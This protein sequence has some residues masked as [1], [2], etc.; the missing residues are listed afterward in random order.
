MKKLTENQSKALDYK[1]HIS[2]TANAGSGKTFVFAKRYVEIAL[3]N[4]ENLS[5]IVAI[6]FT[7]KAAAELYKKISEELKAKINNSAEISEKNRLYNIRRQ[8]VSA[9]IS[10]IHSFCSK[11]LKEFAPELGL[12]SNFVLID[13]NHSLELLEKSFD[14]YINEYLINQDDYDIKTLLRFFGN[15]K[16]FFAGILGLIQ[17][18]RLVSLLLNKVNSLTDDDL[19]QNIEKKNEEFFDILFNVDID[20]ILNDLSLLNNTVLQ[21]NPDNG[22]A[23]Q[24]EVILKSI[25]KLNSKLEKIEGINSVFDIILTTKAQ[26]RKRDYLKKNNSLDSLCSSLE[27][28]ASLIKNL[29]YNKNE[30]DE[31]IYYLRLL[32][33]SFEKVDSIY[34]TKKNN[35]SFI[36]FEDLLIYAELLTKKEN[37]ITSLRNRYFYIMVDEYQDTND[38]QY[39]IFMPILDNLERGNLFVV[40]DE[41]QSIYKFREA[42]IELFDRTRRK[43]SDRNQSGILTLPHS[44]RLSTNVA[45]FVNYIF[46]YL[47]QKEN[48]LFNEVDY[49]ELICVSG[50]KAG[51]VDILISE[52]KFT[53][54]EQI[55]KY[56]TL[57]VSKGEIESFNKI[58]VLSRKRS[59]F[60]E[61]EE[62]F[63][64]FG[65]PYNIIGGI[66][67][68]QRQVVY[69]VLNYCRFLLNNQD[70]VALVGILRSPF[71]LIQDD[72][73]TAIR[74]QNGK[75]FFE[76]LKSYSEIDKKLIP[77]KLLLEKQ[78]KDTLH[79]SVT[80]LLTSV[81]KSTGYITIINQRSDGPQDTGNLKKIIELSISQETKGFQ[82]LYDFVEFLENSIE[83]IHDEGQAESLSEKNSVNIMTIHQAKGLEF[84]NVIIYGM[85]DQLRSEQL[86]SKELYIEKD[87]G[88]QFKIPNNRNYFESY[89]SPV[90][91]VISNLIENKKNIAEEKRL[92]YV[93]MTR[94][95][96]KLILSAKIE[97][98]EINDDSYLG[99][100]TKIPGIDI[101]T[102]SN[103]LK[104]IL[105][106]S[107][108]FEKNISA[109]WEIDIRILKDIESVK[110]NSESEIIKKN[111][112]SRYLKKIA[113]YPENEI[114][115][116]T[117]IA[118]FSQ[119][120]YKYYLTYELGYLKLKKI[121]EGDSDFI[122]KNKQ[123]D[124]SEK[125]MESDLRGIIIHKILEVNNHPASLKETATEIVNLFK[126]HKRE[127]ISGEMFDEITGV[128]D[129]YYNSMTYKQ[130]SEVENCKNE[131]QIY[132]YEQGRYLYGIID[133]VIF[134][135]NTIMIIDYKTDK[136]GKKDIGDALQ[137][138]REQINFYAYIIK[139][140][141]PGFHVKTKIVFIEKP[142]DNKFEL[143]DEKT[144]AQ[145]E[146]LITKFDFINKNGNY[147]K[148]K[149]HC[150]N[151]YYRKL[152]ICY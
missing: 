75:S 47:F 22:L 116:A 149:N 140:I 68:F 23:L 128:I 119:C 26:V 78:I 111:Y 46:S 115:S 61:I 17:R 95:I 120:E 52:N 70:D 6:T 96:K 134:D 51:A 85:N 141:Y 21:E 136:L 30:T 43:I 130:I 65:I 5:K 110:L 123:N 1:S 146:S 59:N 53:E 58:S 54:A 37:I 124:G 48:E 138:Y 27:K 126:T 92:L 133:K 112:D 7:E 29:R 45:F 38:M 143:F 49:S 89:I 76:K 74:L 11:L 145:T 139:K 152:Q 87:L 125:L 25:D 33:K 10:T 151:C 90:S 73:I 93:A 57:A 106:Y 101:N 62:A 50:N 15:K 8:L 24:A 56:I 109:D 86:R 122:E 103:K 82:T 77:V 121:L 72:I 44:F 135:Q 105:N 102:P 20:Q 147:N 12:D 104:G 40:G 67:F 31:Y 32:L 117:K 42:D 88:L 80:E 16:Q 97:K 4:P 150:L 36:D 129:R 34:R 100:L 79:Y 2:L 63:T 69:D 35:E 14:A 39:E 114:L 99:M 107:E 108:G 60:K 118:V 148:N 28:C 83:N 66:G 71:F 18:R 132:F 94:A 64:S 84:D 137:K 142:D 41:K 55:A 144:L 19:K 9:N 91:A 113:D 127:S 3:D 81:L 131:F 98:G 13:S